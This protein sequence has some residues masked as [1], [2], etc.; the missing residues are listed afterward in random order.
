MAILEER[1]PLIK[2]V[3]SVFSDLIHSCQGT[4]GDTGAEQNPRFHILH[5]SK[6]LPGILSV[7][8]GAETELFLSRN[9]IR[10]RPEENSGEEIK[11]LKMLEEELSCSSLHFVCGQ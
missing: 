11:I 7:I 8:P 10:D 2:G 4:P 1:D 5:G 6:T 3:S 9:K